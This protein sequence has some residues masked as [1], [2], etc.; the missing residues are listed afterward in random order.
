MER[1]N[2]LL[3]HIYAGTQGSA[4]TY[5]NEIIEALKE[6]GIEQ[7][8]FV[9]YYYPFRNAKKCFFRI[10]DLA[11]GRKKTKLRLYVRYLELICALFYIFIYSLRYRPAFLNYSLNSSYLPEYIFLILLKRFLKV[12]IIL[13]CH[14][15]IPFE[16]AFLKMS[17]EIKR[18]KSLLEKADYLLVHNDN[19]KN[20]LIRYYG[21]DSCKIIEHPFPIMSLRHWAPGKRKKTI[22]FL[23][24]GHL[25]REKGVKILLEAWKMFHKEYPNAVLYIVGNNPKNSGI[26]PTDFENLNVVFVLNYV[27]DEEYA[28]YISSAKCVVLPYLRGTNSGIPSSVYSLGTELIA[29]DIPMFKNNPLINRDSLFECGNSDSLVEKMKSAYASN[30]RISVAKKLVSYRIFFRNKICEVYSR[31]FD[32]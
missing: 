30:E 22:D 4:G 24:V 26:Y 28:N 3:Y 17:S 14:D 13:T 11:S 9:S 15:V 12:R 21:I 18:R 23:F 19:S 25:R 32:L 1:R 16:N 10:T 27:S 5:L 6:I 20:D 31:L 29:S 2:N 7:R 8:A